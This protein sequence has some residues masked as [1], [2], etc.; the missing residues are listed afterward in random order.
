MLD[1]AITMMLAF[2]V[3]LAVAVV[4]ALRI[5]RDGARPEVKLA[6]DQKTGEYLLFEPAG[7]EAPERT[8]AR[9]LTRDT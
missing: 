6:L 5:R 8:I 9:P 7:P 1:I 4:L 3:F 2:T